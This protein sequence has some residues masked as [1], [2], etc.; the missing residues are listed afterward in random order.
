MNFGFERPVILLLGILTAP[1]AVILSRYYRDISGMDVPLGPPGGIAFKSP[2]NLDLI[3]NIFRVFNIAGIGLLFAAA[4]GPVS[5]YTWTVWLDRGADI[6][7]VLDISPSMAALDMNGRSRF[8]AARNL[9][10]DFSLSR[11]MDA[12]GLAVL[13]S[14]AAMLLPPTLDRD[15]L[16]SRLEKLRIGEMGDGSALGM[17]LAAAALHL[18]NSEASPRAVVLITDGENNAGSVHPHTA[19]AALRGLGASLWIIGVGSS[20]EVPIN[21]TDPFTNIRRTGTF[22]SRFDAE[23][24]RNLSEAGGGVYI[25]APSGEALSAAFSR[26]DEAEKTSRRSASQSR[27]Q[28]LAPPLLFISLLIIVISR[29]IRMY[30]LGA[31]I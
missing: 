11:P 20:G 5:V 12:I 18:K 24:L 2:V 29:F 25:S 28:S 26:F 16:I 23:S 13:G 3:V 9:I 4:A 19:A 30:I 17:G 27:L 14:D 7:F 31:L 15:S 1:V 6:V 8:D 21:Y 10:R 22:D